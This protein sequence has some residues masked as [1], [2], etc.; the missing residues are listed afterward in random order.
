[1]ARR[2]PCAYCGKPG[3]TKDHV[4]PRQIY[5]VSRASSRVQLLTVPACESCNG[6]WSDDEVVFRNVLTLCG[7]TPN[8]ARKELW[9]ST[10]QRSF[11]EADGQHRIAQLADR[12]RAIDVHGQARTMIFPGKDQSVLRVVR[13]AIR[14]LSYHHFM[15]GCVPDERVWAD[16]L[17]YKVP[18][19]LLPELQ[20]SHRDPEVVEYW[21]GKKS[22]YGFTST[23]LLTFY[24]TVTFIG[25][26]K[27][28]DVQARLTSG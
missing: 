20:H 27:E 12:M 15:E 2:R 9:A 10:I 11:A 17:L 7:E 14:G 3:T 18:D 23:W 26:V 21:F 8:E 25:A 5:P 1:M 28:E 16:V 6:S 22:G 4:F 24:R 13:K 19:H